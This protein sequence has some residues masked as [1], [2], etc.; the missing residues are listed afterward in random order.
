M[1]NNNIDNGKL[2][3]YFEVKE[4]LDKGVNIIYTNCLDF[5][6]F[7]YLNKGYDVVAIKS[8]GDYILLSELLSNSKE[9]I[10]TNKEMRTAHNARKMLVAGALTFRVNIKDKLRSF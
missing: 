7:S 6:C 3:S 10:Y 5:F 2:K 1:S 8:N 9:H 4:D